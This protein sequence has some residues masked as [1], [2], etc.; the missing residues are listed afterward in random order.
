MER[1]AAIITATVISATVLSASG[2]LAATSGA[3]DSPEPE[4]IADVSPVAVEAEPTDVPTEPEV[5][6][7]TIDEPS[8]SDQSSPAP[9]NAPSTPM[10]SPSDGGTAPVVTLADDHD[11][12]RDDDHD[13]HD[14]DDDDHDD[15]DHGDHDR[16]DD[17]PDRDDDDRDDDDD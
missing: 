5:I 13:D 8:I 16:D 10:A 15:D 11:H 17:D 14:R 2:V 12:D 9:A 4:P 3:F 6:T 7:V 1:K